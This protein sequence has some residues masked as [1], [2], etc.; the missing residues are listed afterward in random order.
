MRRKVLAIDDSLTLR[1]FISRTLSSDYEVVLA[2]D[3]NEGVSQAAGASPEL[4]LLD[5]VL[6]DIKG[7]EV[8]RRLAGN[9]ATQHLPVILMSSNAEDI[10]RT[11]AQF[12]R[13]IKAIAKP[14]TP[15]LLFSAV[16]CAFRELGTSAPAPEP[17]AQTEVAP[18]ADA[19]E[20]AEDELNTDFISRTNRQRPNRNSFSGH[21]GVAPMHQFLRA[22]EH[23]ALSGVLR[24]FIGETALDLHVSEGVPMLVTTADV[25]LYL[26]QGQH[27][28]SPE[29]NAAV[30]E[31][32][33]AQGETGCPIFLTLREKGLINQREA[34]A[35]CE[36]YG[37]RLFSQ[38]WTAVRP[39]VKFQSR[40]TRLPWHIKPY[41]GTMDEWA[42]D[43]LRQI[44]DEFLSSLAWGEPTGIPAY[45]RQGYDRIQE[46]ALTDE[47]LAFANLVSPRNSL[48]TIA[49]TLDADIK[50]AQRIL[51]RFWCMGIYEY[52]P[53]SLLRG[54]AQ[55]SPEQPAAAQN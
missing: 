24:V 18:A 51:F 35:L 21:T 41:A 1:E 12:S 3:G 8:C 40:R 38:V 5:F 29:Q 11:Q 32:R 17:A 13:V 46:I 26:K 15:E 42:M 16:N 37:L 2:K 45:T 6:P 9:P 31:A 34:Q 22:I 10:Q 20:A 39:Q 50:E 4:V 53:A 52:W 19:G 30:E 7:D 25:D 43:T 48:Q 28:F 44:G 49:R 36:N 14:F 54:S 27:I 55:T 23:D 47:E 33:R